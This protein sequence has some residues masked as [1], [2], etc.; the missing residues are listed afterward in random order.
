MQA[1]LRSLPS[2]ISQLSNALVSLGSN[3]G[4]CVMWMCL[5]RTKLRPTSSFYVGHHDVRWVGLLCCNEFNNFLTDLVQVCVSLIFMLLPVPKGWGFTWVRTGD[6]VTWDGVR[7]SPTSMAV[8][9]SECGVYDKCQKDVSISATLSPSPVLSRGGTTSD[10]V[11]NSSCLQLIPTQFWGKSKVLSLLPKGTLRRWVSEKRTHP[12][13]AGP[14]TFLLWS[15]ALGRQ[16]LAPPSPWEYR[17]QIKEKGKKNHFTASLPR[18]RKGSWHQQTNQRWKLMRSRFPFSSIILLIFS[19]WLGL[20]RCPG[21]SI[22][23]KA[24]LAVLWSTP[25]TIWIPVGR[26]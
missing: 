20:E 2:S 16:V 19:D 4:L 18:T 1:V 3:W 15:R 13:A 10:Q 6:G 8:D 24:F 11:R 14:F 23:I 26:S 17:R 5:G 7:V 9:A 21:K 12:L 22:N 25:K